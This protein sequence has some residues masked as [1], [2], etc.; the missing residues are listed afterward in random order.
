MGET[1]WF[2]RIWRRIRAA[3]KAV[4]EFIYGMTIYDMVRDLNKERARIQRLFIVMVFGDIMGVP[5]L[6]PYYTL[7]LLP[8][9]VPTLSV[10]K[11]HL[12]RERDL[13]D[14]LDQELG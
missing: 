2:N 9:V 14:M 6:P 11:R 3:A 8:Y 4:G 1:G 13:T 12:A 10:W 7:R 5:L